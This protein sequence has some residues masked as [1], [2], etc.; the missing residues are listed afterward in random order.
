MAIRPYQV[1]PFAPGEPAGPPVRPQIRP[2]LLRLGLDPDLYQFN[3]NVMLVLEQYFHYRNCDY[4]G[5]AHYSRMDEL[6]CNLVA[7]GMDPE[8]RARFEQKIIPNGMYIGDISQ[9]ELYR[10]L[11]EGSQFKRIVVDSV[12]RYSIG[13]ITNRQHRLDGLENRPI[14]DRERIGLNIIEEAS[15]AG[16]EAATPEISEMFQAE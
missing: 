16:I 9:N 3:P 1:L 10:R 13:E 8:T 6:D 2:E 4:R 5:V 12:R 14:A 7:A 15:A 11:E